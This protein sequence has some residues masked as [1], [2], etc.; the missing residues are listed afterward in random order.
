MKTISAFIVLVLISYVSDYA[1][2]DG[3]E[4]PVPPSFQVIDVQHDLI[5]F[6]SQIAQPLIGRARWP[7]SASHLAVEFREVRLPDFFS[8]VDETFHA[9]ELVGQTFEIVSEN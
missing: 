6:S 3:P 7:G 5:R 8:P 9:L 4:D 2:V 1:T